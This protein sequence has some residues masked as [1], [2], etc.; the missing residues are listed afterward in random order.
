MEADRNNAKSFEIEAMKALLVT[1]TALIALGGHALAADLP[2][3]APVAPPV[4]YVDWGGCYVGAHVGGA[5]GR[6]EFTDPVGGPSGFGP[7]A[8]SAF[9]AHP[10]GVQ[11]GGQL[12][13]NYQFAKNWVFGLEADFSYGNIKGGTFD[14]FFGGKNLEERT[15]W[16]TSATGHLGYTFDRVL[17]YGK[18]GSAWARNSIDIT[19]LPTRDASAK[20][21]RP[22]YVIG[23]GFEYALGN[24]WSA[25]LEYDHYD[26]GAHM[27][28][29]FDPVNA[30]VVPAQISQR[31]DAVNVG[32]NYRFGPVGPLIA[33]Y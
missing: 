8:G 9:T 27:V 24:N 28:T 18:L 3:K 11:G 1:T 5:W 4:P 26:F 2:V 15:N 32:I 12:G 29:L 13:C 19:Q 16:L 22:G 21:I 10:T 30:N 33:K 6:S 25:R 20:E 7:A 23:A 17:V 31:I 14:P